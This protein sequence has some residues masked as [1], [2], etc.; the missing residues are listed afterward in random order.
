MMPHINLEDLSS[1]NNLLHLLNSR[2]QKDPGSFAR[3]DS[4]GFDTALAM[5]AVKPA[6]PW[7][8]IMLLTDQTTRNDYGRLID[9]EAVGNAADLENI[10]YTGFG[11]L[12]GQG[13]LVLKL[14]KQLYSFLVKCTQLLL[15]DLDLSRLTTVP[16]PMASYQHEPLRE[17][18]ASAE[19]TEWQ[20]VSETNTW[21]SY[22]LPQP[23]SVEALRKLA[24][25][26][27]DEYVSLDLYFL[28]TVQPLAM[29]LV[30]R[31]ICL[32]FFMFFRPDASPS[33]RT[34]TTYVFTDPRTFSGPSWKI[35]QFSK[36]S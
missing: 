26:K 5:K 23:F 34:L 15:D 36:N 2:S 8:T 21:L 3:T 30:S 31:S 22:D 11:F 9:I 17:S 19:E 18:K 27:R 28:S 35:L 25:A 29:R 4:L 1:Q 14:Q 24:G 20:S 7:K 32:D 10:I 12:L 13:L 6:T 33:K 16:F